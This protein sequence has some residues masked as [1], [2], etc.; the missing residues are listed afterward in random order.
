[1]RWLEDFFIKGRTYF[2]DAER[3]RLMTIWFV[4]LKKNLEKTRDSP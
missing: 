3:P 2:H 4:N 1:M